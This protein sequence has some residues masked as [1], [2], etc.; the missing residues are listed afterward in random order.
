MD[1]KNF[2]QENEEMKNEEVE[3]QSEDLAE[4]TQTPDENSEADYTLD[5]DAYNEAQEEI[6]SD[7]TEESA[8]NSDDDNFLEE[9]AEYGSLDNE[10]TGGTMVDESGIPINLQENDKKKSPLPIIIVV[11][12]III[13]LIIATVFAMKNDKNPYNPMDY[14]VAEGTTI[15]DIAESYG[16][17]LSEFLSVY[18]LPEDMPA[19][20]P[21]YSSEYYIPCD[22]F[23]QMAGYE[24][25]EALK[26]VAQ[27][28]DETTVSEPTTLWEK[29]KS[30]FIKEEPQ[31]I[32]GDTY[33]G[34][35]LDEMT[36]G[37][38]VGEEYMDEFKEL[39]GLGD[40]ITIDTKYKEV[41]P[42]I[43]DY[44]RTQLQAQIDQA[45]EQ[46]ENATDNS[47]EAE[48]IDESPENS[49]ETT[50]TDIDEASE[51]TDSVAEE[52]E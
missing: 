16:V 11:I 44:I 3:E 35:A 4:E 37:V 21:S 8:E 12:I 27:I 47:N 38:Y 34:V 2:N 7:D 9:K 23:A 42:M 30:I 20:T 19:D 43:E 46:Q 22:I 15:G 48:N 45:Q 31:P 33:W 36:L 28:P 41:R 51:Q 13:A 26:E 32:T 6:I 25:F 29:I 5:E 18:G 49:E 24:N 40:D 17:E 50:S 39:Y 14:P 1:E 10:P 52:S